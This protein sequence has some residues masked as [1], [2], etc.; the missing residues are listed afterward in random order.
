MFQRLPA[1]FLVIQAKGKALEQSH[2]SQY[3]F[4]GCKPAAILHSVVDISDQHST[5]QGSVT[6]ELQCL[7]AE[8]CELMLWVERVLE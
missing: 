1:V 2:Q 8:H 5:S 6:T 4:H 3:S 7:M